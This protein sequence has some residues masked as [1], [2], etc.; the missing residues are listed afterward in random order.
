MISTRKFRFIKR[1][2]SPWLQKNPIAHRGLHNNELCEN[3][4]S[5]FTAAVELSIP[6]ELDVHLTADN[7]I[8]V[9]H[10]DDLSRMC[11]TPH[12]VQ[13]SKFTDIS[14]F[15]LLNTPE[16]IPTLSEVLDMVNAKVPLLIEVKTTPRAKEI[17]EVLK[18]TLHSYH[19]EIALQSFS[20][21]IVYLLRKELPCHTVGFISG[22]YKTSVQP[23]WVKWLLRNLIPAFVLKPDFVAYE[24]SRIRKIAPQLWRRL[25]G[26]LIAWTVNTEGQKM[27]ANEFAGNYI[28]DN[29]NGELFQ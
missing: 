9:F 29:P 10:D 1:N 4:L 26:A 19:G 27:L 24:V 2:V 12:R 3:S 16:T 25:G 13:D 7:I 21:S 17:V 15:P 22:S 6:I 28:F 14:Q 18:Q 20:P 23:F 11:G 8:V 5:A